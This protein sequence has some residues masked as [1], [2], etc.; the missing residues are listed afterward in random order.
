MGEGQALYIFSVSPY[1]TALLP[2]THGPNPGAWELSWVLVA[3][4]SC[5]SGSQ[6]LG[7]S[8]TLI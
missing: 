7:P 8:G 2:S 4:T 1:L 5:R 6:S 3:V